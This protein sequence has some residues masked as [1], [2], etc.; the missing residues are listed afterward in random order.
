MGETQKLNEAGPQC[1][2]DGPIPAHRVGDPPQIEK[3]FQYLVNRHVA[4]PPRERPPG[5]R[6]LACGKISFSSRL[7]SKE[8]PW[9]LHR[10]VPRRS[11][12]AHV[13]RQGVDCLRVSVASTTFSVFLS[14]RSFCIFV[15]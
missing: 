12:G 6:S 11:H 5:G 7:L 13:F 8:E 14:V 10:R 4:D 2:G 9:N 1:R 3:K 15:G